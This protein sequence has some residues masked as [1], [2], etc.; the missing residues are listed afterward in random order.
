MTRS[1]TYVSGDGTLDEAL[2]RIGELAARLWEVRRRHDAMRDRL[3][4]WR[5]PSCRGPAPCPTA[6]AVSPRPPGPRR[7]RP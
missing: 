5:C 6:L 3:G 7:S 2:D 4:R 1:G